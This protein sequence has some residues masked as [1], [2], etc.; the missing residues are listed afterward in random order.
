MDNATTLSLESLCGTHFLSGVE[1]TSEEYDG[2]KCEVCLFKLDDVTYKLVEDP[3]DGYRSYCREICVTKSEPQYAFPEI[4]VLCY[5]M[6]GD[7]NVLVFKDTANGET[8]L[9]VG[10]LDIYDW[11]PCC[12]FKYTPENMACNHNERKATK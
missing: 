5:M 1:L 8:I 2:E 4:E 3:D 12:H 6:S 11:Y 10:T 7:N 9:E